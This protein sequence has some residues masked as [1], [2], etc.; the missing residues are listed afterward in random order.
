MMWRRWI[1]RALSSMSY[2]AFHPKGLATSPCGT[3]RSAGNR[4]SVAPSAWRRERPDCPSL[5]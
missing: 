4:T 3:P 1:V 5:S 2:T